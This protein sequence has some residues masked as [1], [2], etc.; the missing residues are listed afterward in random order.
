MNEASV[1]LDAEPAARLLIHELEGCERA[2]IER[3][4]RRC[5]VHTQRIVVDQEHL[6]CSEDVEHVEVAAIKLTSDPQ[7]FMFAADLA[8]RAPWVQLV[9]WANESAP[10]TGAHVARSLGIAR[11]VPSSQIA[12]WLAVAV[13][14][15]A[16]LARAQRAA[17]EAE[18]TIPCV[19]ALTAPSCPPTIALPEAE[20][21]FRESYLR[22]LLSESPNA[23]RAA[24]RAG[25]PYTTLC[26]M[27]KKLGLSKSALNF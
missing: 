27:I 21:Q 10:T 7:G 5:R 13:G 4:L 24:E 25:V 23:K 16:R 12:G 2:D 1:K 6:P 22:Q 20:R 26:S 17:R 19:P 3:E 14:P 8:K 15:L 9:F 18:A 11:V